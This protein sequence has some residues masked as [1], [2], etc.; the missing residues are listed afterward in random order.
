MPPQTS[1]LCP[2][3][4][5]GASGIVPVHLSAEIMCNVPTVYLSSGRVY[6]AQ[7][8]GLRTA[9]TTPPGGTH[10][11]KP[12][13]LFSSSSIYHEQMMYTHVGVCTC[14]VDRRNRKS[15]NSRTNGAACYNG[16]CFYIRSEA[17]GIHELVNASLVDVS[18][19]LCNDVHNVQA[20]FQKSWKTSVLKAA[21]QWDT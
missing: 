8:G 20:W 15:Q 14:A 21:M 10:H 16:A 9:L 19:K 18:F 12:F 2:C 11:N 17:T 1:A 13:P 3:P 4:S 7:T 6:V 5:R